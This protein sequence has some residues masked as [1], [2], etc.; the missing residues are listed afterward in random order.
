M[1]KKMFERRYF[2]IGLISIISA[3]ATG[4][5]K[6]DAWDPI[7]AA[8]NPCTRLSVLVLLNMRK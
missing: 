5:N 3:A 4:E 8:G 2:F 6:R 7:K 1:N